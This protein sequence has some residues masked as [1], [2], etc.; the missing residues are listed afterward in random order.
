MV[1]EIEHD[2]LVYVDRRNNVMKLAQGEFVATSFLEAVFAAAPLIQQIYIYGNSQRAGLLAVVVPTVEAQHSYPEPRQLRSAI[3]HSLQETAQSA[4][5]RSYELPIDLLI[6]S[7]P[8]STSNGLL[9]GIGKNL[10]GKLRAQ[11]GQ[12]LERLYAEISQGQVDERRALVEG[13]ATLPVLDTVVQACGL[14][15]GSSE[16]SPSARFIEL[17]GDSLSALTLST[18]LADIYQVDV[19]VGRDNQPDC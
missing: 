15:I 11:Y 14:V 6:E 19:P 1:A 5:L 16:P 4:E 3:M 17:G 12:R 13:A 9:S 7:Q 8:F 10:H 18:L 2:Q